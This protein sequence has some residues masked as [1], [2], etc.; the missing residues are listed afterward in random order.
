M[1]KI[2]VSAEDLR[3]DSF[4]IEGEKEER[5]TVEAHGSYPGM[6]CDKSQDTTTAPYNSVDQC[7][8]NWSLLS[9]PDQTCHETFSWTGC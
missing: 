2:R 9:C 6:A 7:P 4:E 8:C 3:V 1:E 5:G